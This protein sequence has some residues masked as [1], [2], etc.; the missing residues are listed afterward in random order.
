MH[1]QQYKDHTGSLH[2]LNFFKADEYAFQCSPEVTPSYIFKYPESYTEYKRPPVL[3]LTYERTTKTP[4]MPEF[5]FPG[6]YAPGNCI[7]Y[8]R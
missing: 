3:P 1:R 5:A 4:Y 6:I 8:K 7:A 2:P